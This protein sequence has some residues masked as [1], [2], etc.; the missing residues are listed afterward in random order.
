MCKVAALVH[1]WH[2]IAADSRLALGGS[3]L[4][5][6][7]TGG[8]GVSRKGEFVAVETDKERRR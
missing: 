1:F 5:A 6:I 7:L 3:Y 4:S 2:F 8:W